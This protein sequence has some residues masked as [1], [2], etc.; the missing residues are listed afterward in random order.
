MQDKTGQDKTGEIDDMNP[1]R[2]Q[3]SRRLRDLGNS[4]QMM[5]CL[6]PFNLSYIKEVVLVIAWILF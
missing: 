4:S 5:T 6:L 3:C 2:V 1:E